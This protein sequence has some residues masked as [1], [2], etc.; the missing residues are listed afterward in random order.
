MRAALGASRWRLVRQLLTESVL[1][2]LA[3][4]ALGL[5]LAS[6]G[7]R[8]RSARWARAA[9]RGS[10]EIAIDGACCCS[11]SSCRCCRGVLFGL[12]PAL[13]LSVAAICTSNLKDASRGSAGASAV[14]G[15]GQNLRRAARRRRA[16]A[17]GRCCSSAPDCSSEASPTCSSVPPGFDAVQRAHARTDDDGPKVQ[18]CRRPCCEAYRQLWERL[19]ALPGV[20]AA[21]GVSALPL[22]QMMAWGP[23]TVEGRARRARRE[24]HQ[25]RQ[26]VVGGDYFARWR[27]RCA[28][29]GLFTRA[30]TRERRRAWSSI[31]ERM[32]DQFWPGEDP[33]GKRI[34]TGGFDV[35]P[36]HAVDDGRRRRRRR[37]AGR[38][39]CR[40]AH[41][42]CTFPGAD[43][44]ARH[45]RRRAQRPPTRRRSTSAVTQR[46]PGARS[47]P[48]DL[49]HAD[50]G[51]A[52]RRIAGASGG[53]RC[54][55]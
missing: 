54:C 2:A 32:A 13:R 27:F 23:I 7:L 1:L 50:D 19:S 24:V 34:R 21:G 10:H 43:A 29:A 3:G 9:C 36:R 42:R 52:R 45:E 18:R 14:W 35:T 33:I 22:S 55:C 53:S 16:R 26:R 47:R 25:R 37:Q 6:V 28:G 49:Q 51:G 41:R 40:L 4:G 12:A 11:R 5:L 48:A 38:A 44:V 30:A 46:D 17:L 39:R 20:T 31:D 15:R 8:R